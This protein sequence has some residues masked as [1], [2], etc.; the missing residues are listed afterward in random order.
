MANQFDLTTSK[1]RDSFNRLLQVGND[2][3]LYDGTGSIQQN[4]VFSGTINT[5]GSIKALTGFTGSLTELYNGDS[6]IEQGIGITVVTGASGQI[7]VGGLDS[8]FAT[9]T[10]SMFS[11]SVVVSG[12]VK[13]F[14]GLSGSLTRLYDGQTYIQAGYNTAVVTGASGQVTIGDIAG[15]G[16]DSAASYILVGVTSSLA[17]ERALTAGTGISLT[18]AGA[19]ST[20]TISAL[21]SILATLTGSV[22]SGTINVSGNVKSMTGFSGSLTRLYNGDSYIQAGSNI[23]VTTG[24]SGQVTIDNALGLGV[25]VALMMGPLTSF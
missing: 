21:D 24:A 13:S 17:N 18:D 3:I 15:I 23:A 4:V 25:T 8:I 2:G 5:S 7:T 20:L 10:G 22:F 6:F 16:A 12:N 14:T 19:G 9:L 11:G 1:I